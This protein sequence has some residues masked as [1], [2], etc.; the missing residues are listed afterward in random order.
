M[1]E[2]LK[3]G[4][5]VELPFGPLKR[6]HHPRQQQRGRYLNKITSIY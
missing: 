5:E 6:V 1:A 4:E 3:R 2:A